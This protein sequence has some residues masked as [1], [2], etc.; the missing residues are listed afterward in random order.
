MS[1]TMSA[2]KFEQMRRDNGVTETPQL[3]SPVP[4]VELSTPNMSARDF[5]MGRSKEVVTVN[6]SGPEGTMGIKMRA[7]LSKREVKAHSKFL[8]L[9]RNPESVSEDDANVGA[10]KFL[11]AI[12]LDPELDEEFWSSEELDSYIAQELLSAFME[13]A[14]QSLQG[15]KKFR[16]DR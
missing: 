16:R 3:S 2:E 15:V 10:S 8:E 12:T 6:V 14:A 9:F 4:S 13:H 5:I 1:N 11:A 7:R